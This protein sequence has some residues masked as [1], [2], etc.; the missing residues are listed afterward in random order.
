[1]NHTMTYIYEVYKE[2]SFSQ[3]AK[4]LFISQPALSTYIKKAEAEFGIQIFDRSSLPIKLTE[5]GELYIQA[6]QRIMAVEKDLASQLEELSNLE[7]GHLV[8]AGANFFSAYILPPIIHAFIQKYP[9]IDIQITESDSNTLY[10]EA[11]QDN[12]NLILD[13]GTCDKSLFTT[14]YLCSEKILFAVPISNPLNQMYQSV[15]LSQEDILEDKHLSAKQKPVPLNSFKEERLILLRKGHDMHSRSI[16]I[17]ER[18]GFTPLN[19]MYLNQLSTAANICAQGLGCCFL[20]DTLIKYGPIRDNSLLFY[21]LDDKDACRDMFIAY[22][23]N[24]RKNK[25]MEQFIQ[26]AKEIYSAQIPSL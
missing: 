18:S 20:T 5:A 19:P 14:E 17:C 23:I 4:N 24:S 8:I 13:A 7:R 10:T 21:T 15:A 1:M 11:L 25:A 12:I 3:A 16:S 6:I 26:V 22:Q 2:K 9:K